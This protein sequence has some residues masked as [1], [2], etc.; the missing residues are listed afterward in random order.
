[1]IF[2]LKSRPEPEAKPDK[3]TLRDR[4]KRG[5]SRTHSVLFADVRDLV[6]GKTVLDAATLE[7]LEDR[8]LLADLGVKATTHII[9]TLRSELKHGEKDDPE[10]ILAVLRETL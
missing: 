3:Q 5:L 6:P 7:E 4:L 10:R 1:M 9:N 8:L 2:G